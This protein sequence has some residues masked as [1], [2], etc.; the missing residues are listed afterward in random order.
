MKL[1]ESA[2][3]QDFTYFERY[4]DTDLKRSFS[5]EISGKTEYFVP[6]STGLYTS[7]LDE[8]IHL[9]K[10]LGRSKDAKDQYGVCGPVYR[11][12]RD[13]YWKNKQYNKN[14]RVFYLDIE[15]RSGVYSVGFPVPD[16]ALEEISLI[17]VFDNITKTVYVFG[18]RP[19]TLYSDYH[20]DYPVKYFNFKTEQEMLIGFFNFFQKFDP[21][22]IYAWNGMGF[23]FPYIYNRLR[24]IGLNTNL[25]SNYGETALETQYLNGKPIFKLHSKGHFWIDLMDVYKKFTFAPR[26]SYSLDNIAKIEV[27][28]NK[29]EHTEFTSFD[30]FYT[31]E[32]YNISNEPYTDRVRE[33]IR[34]LQI[35]KSKGEDVQ[36][37][38]I[39]KVNFQFVYYGIQ[40]V[41]LLKKIDDKLN[42]TKLQLQIAE[43]MGVLVGDALGTVR[44]WSQYISNVA[45]LED[46][47]MPPR[48]EHP[49]PHVVGGFVRDPVKGK[50]HWVLNGDVNSMY[51]KLSMAAFNMSPETFV[52]ISRLPSDLREKILMYFNNQVEEERLKM[53]RDIW[54]SVTA[55]LQ[56]YNYSLGINGAVYTRDHQGIIPRLVT[57][58]YDGRKQHKKTMLKYE[59]QKTIIKDILH[60]RKSKDQ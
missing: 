4:Y 44:P 24:N 29:V 16:K 57:Q 49:N 22:I 39:E 37:E 58:I 51:P 55:L 45:M 25:M 53:P 15:T 43:M 35:R 17:Q 54:D 32:G 50:H 33:E 12:I 36:S 59:N 14:P 21:L 8:S 47:V 31:G 3:T 27:H 41:L 60:H 6:K 38:L 30:S 52:P 9:D 56:K 20:L 1:F 5:S 7:I 34:Q 23:D 2:W 10:M 26:S 11:H 48:A 42:F 18:L 46:K 19:W 28:D 40:D 13:N